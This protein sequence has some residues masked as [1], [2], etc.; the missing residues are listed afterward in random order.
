MA[1][2]GIKSF[3]PRSLFGRS[4]AILLV[5]IIVLQLVVGFVFFQRHYQRVTQQMTASVAQ[6]LNFAI[7]NVNSSADSSQAADRLNG[8]AQALAI[9]AVLDGGEQISPGVER[10][11][12]DITGRTVVNTLIERIPHDL[13]IDLSA[14]D[15]IALIKTR[16]EFGV[17]RMMV[18]RGRLS[19]SNPHQL[20]V[21]MVMV[22]LLLATTAVLFLRNQVRPIR[23][24]AEASEA[25]GKG[26]T[27]EFR[28][29]GAEEVRRA[30]GAFINMRS[31]IERQ[32]EQRTQMLSGV[33][34]DLRTPLTRMKLTLAMM[35]DD[36]DTRALRDD[37]DQMSLMLEGFLD[38]ARGDATE[39]TVPTNPF[40]LASD[41]V[42]KQMRSGVR[43]DLVK[44][45]ESTESELV[46]L[47]PVAV[48]RALQN[49]TGNAA[50]FGTRVRLTVRLNANALVF[51]VEDNGPGIPEEQRAEAIQP[52]TRLDPSRNLDSGSNVGLGLSIAADIARSHGGALE[53]SESADLG[54][55]RIEFRI[56]R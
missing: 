1:A 40:G 28:P 36:E 4:L 23:R 19:V 11:V 10:D 43:I 15:D 51:V 32:I 16:T 52:F 46:S 41:I 42:G 31:R 37:V 50:R 3:L 34:H 8:I 20:L 29:S 47:R 39:E 22:S 26:R 25:F 2:S 44:R 12:L 18:P 21:L 6:G 14:D 35:E 13:M 30:G 45:N 54:G 9:D 48:S 38:F 7:D 56:P 24:L 5:P 17:L 49:L 27:H 33:S 53:L 55:L